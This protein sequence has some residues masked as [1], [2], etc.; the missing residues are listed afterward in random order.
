MTRDF[1]VKSHIPV[2]RYHFHSL[3]TPGGTNTKKRVTLDFGPAATLDMQRTW[4][5]AVETI[6]I[7]ETG[8][9]GEFALRITGTGYSSVRSNGDDVGNTA[10]IV[11]AYQFQQGNLTRGYMGTQITNPNFLN[12]EITI[13]LLN[14]TD[15]REIVAADDVHAFAV[16]FVVYEYVPT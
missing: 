13:E 7:N 11:S 4:M 14:G 8:P 5:L 3:R 6:M 10:T 9:L 1:Y 15:L 16:T 12:S 2:H